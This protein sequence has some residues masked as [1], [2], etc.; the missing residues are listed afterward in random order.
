M[1]SLPK[2]HPAIGFSFML[3]VVPKHIKNT[4]SNNMKKEI[5]Y[6]FLKIKKW[7]VLFPYGLIWRLL[8][9]ILPNEFLF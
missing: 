1:N 2:K 6:F 4:T 5:S 3:A 9:V 8:E 7:N